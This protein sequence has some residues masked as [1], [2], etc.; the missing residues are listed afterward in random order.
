MAQMGERMQGDDAWGMEGKKQVRL[1]S[2]EQLAKATA[3]L[4]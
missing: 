2:R 4:C 1:W 3:F